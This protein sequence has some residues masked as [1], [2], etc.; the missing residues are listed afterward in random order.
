MPLDFNDFDL[1]FPKED[2][3]KD[4]FDATLDELLERG[5]R[6]ED[7]DLY[8]AVQQLNFIE[9]ERLLKL[10]ADPRCIIEEEQ[11]GSCIKVVED[12]CS[13][14]EI[15]LAPYYLNQ[16]EEDISGYSQAFEDLFML[17]ANVCM[18]KLL[19][20]YDPKKRA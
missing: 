9:T 17:A 3:Y 10:G 1:G 15:E 12:E 4:F 13:F 18:S 8:I 5:N 20:K 19:S 11:S 6:T 7:L 14:L 2:S 16:D